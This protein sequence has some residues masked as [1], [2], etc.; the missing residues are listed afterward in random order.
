MVGVHASQVDMFKCVALE[1]LALSTTVSFRRM[2]LLQADSRA[3]PDKVPLSRRACDFSSTALLWRTRRITGLTVLRTFSGSTAVELFRCLLY[4]TL[5]VVVC[6]MRCHLEP[7]WQMGGGGLH[8]A[9]T[10]VSRGAAIK[11]LKISIL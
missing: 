4:R 7:Q 2:F 5:A 1:G 11:E 9:V 6:P 10:T 3:S 8:I